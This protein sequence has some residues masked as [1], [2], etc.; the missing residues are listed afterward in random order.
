MKSFE[1]E[2]MSVLD[3]FT[4]DVKDVA[5]KDF[6]KVAQDTV[7]QL[8]ASSPRKTGAYASG[9]AMKKEAG[10]MGDTSYTIYNSTMP[11]LTHLLENGHAKAGGG[12]VG[13]IKHIA[14]AE[15]NAINSLIIKLEGDL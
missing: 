14:P 4:D 1:V 2:L 15:Q 13:A 6:K 12:A 8:K 9:W 5:E 11:G 7:K 10:A 3:E